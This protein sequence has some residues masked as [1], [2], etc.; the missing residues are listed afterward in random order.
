[1]LICGV[2]P[3]TTQMLEHLDGEEGQRPIF[4]MRPTAV[5]PAV[6]DAGEEETFLAFLV[7]RARSVVFV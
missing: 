6:M 1:M 4:A 5:L 7:Q 3:V 2:I